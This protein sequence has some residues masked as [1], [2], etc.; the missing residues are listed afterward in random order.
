MPKP[1]ERELLKFFRTNT[2]D[3]PEVTSKWFKLPDPYSP[4]SLRLRRPA[5][6]ATT[7]RFLRHFDSTVDDLFRGG[8][9]EGVIEYATSQ[10]VAAAGQFEGYQLSAARRR[11]LEDRAAAQFR[12]FDVGG[13]FFSNIGRLRVFYNLSR[14]ADLMRI[15]LELGVAAQKNDIIDHFYLADMHQISTIIIWNNIGRPVPR[16]LETRLIDVEIRDV[17]S[18]ILARLIPDSPSG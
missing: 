5:V 17:Q 10:L 11:I 15:G 18:A 8:R 9:E 1:L 4:S 2:E 14:S 13:K 7:Q 3:L 6:E 16:Y 12:L